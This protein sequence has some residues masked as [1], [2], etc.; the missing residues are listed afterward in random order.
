MAGGFGWTPCVK[1][2]VMSNPAMFTF[3]TSA[4][5][6]QGVS[7]KVDIARF[8]LQ[9]PT[10]YYDFS[11]D[12]YLHLRW[13]GNYSGHVHISLFLVQISSKKMAASKINSNLKKWLFQKGWI[14]IDAIWWLSVLTSIPL[15][16]KLNMKADIIAVYYGMS[17]ERS[18]KIL[19]YVWL[20]VLRRYLLQRSIVSNNVDNRSGS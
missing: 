16:T 7:N 3:A 20:V 13:L 6:V 5:I 14:I 15:Q 12:R 19:R 8:R 11:F 1:M 10:I 18:I 4:T 2:M 17:V 9:N